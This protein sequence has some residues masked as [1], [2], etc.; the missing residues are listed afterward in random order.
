VGLEGEGNNTFI[1]TTSAIIIQPGDTV[2]VVGE[3]RVVKDLR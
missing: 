3:K 2:W 1:R